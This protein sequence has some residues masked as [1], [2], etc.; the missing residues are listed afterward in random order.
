[1]KKTGYIS[2]FQLLL[3]VSISNCISAQVVI[4]EYSCSNIKRYKYILDTIYY[5]YKTDWGSVF[6][7]PDKQLDFI[8]S[9]VTE[10]DTKDVYIY[11][12]W[13][14]EIDSSYSF[15]VDNYDKTED[16]IE[17]YN[18][19]KNPV[20]IS[21]YYLSDNP[22]KPKKFKIHST[23][24]IPSGG[25][26]LIW[27]S[28]RDT[29]INDT[30]HASFK[31]TQTGDESES[32]LF[33]DANGQLVETLKI[34]K[35][36]SHHSHG[37]LIDNSE[38][39]AIFPLPTPGTT[40]N[41]AIHFQGYCREPEFSEPAG[42]YNDSVLI[43]IL[44]LD[45]T[46]RIYYTVDGSEPDT[47]STLYNG[48]PI[49]VGSTIVLKAL[50]VSEDEKL[51]S[52]FTQ[53]A[54]YFINEVHTIPVISIA[55][56]LLDSLAEGNKEC[57]PW[58]S[59]EYFDKEKQ[60]KTSSFGE[61]N[62]HGQDSWAN[63][64]RSI[65]FIAKDQ[66]G[67]AGELIEKFFEISDR[68]HFQRLILRAAGD[69][70]YPATTDGIQNYWNLGSAHMRDAYFQ[71][72]CK[73]GGM[74][75]DVRKATKCIIYLNGRYWGVYDIRENPDEHDYTK[76]YYDQDEF[77]LQ[78]ILTWG[79]TWA[80]YGGDKAL[81]D[82]NELR[83]F[84]VTNN[85]SIQE[86][87]DKAV[88]ELDAESLADYV[89]GHSFSVSSDWLLYN[90][91]WWRGL[92]PDGEHKRWGYILW[93]NDASFAFYINYTGIPDT[94][95][96]AALCNVDGLQGYSDPEK[97][98]KILNKLRQNSSFNNYYIMRYNDMMNTAFSCEN[99]LHQLDSVRAILEPEMHRHTERWP[100]GSYEEWQKNVDRLRYFIERRCGAR[101]NTKLDSCY[102]LTGPYDITF[103]A[104]PEDG[105]DINVNSLLINDFPWN[106][107]YFGGANVN[108]NAL[109]DPVNSYFFEKWMA[110]SN[111]FLSPETDAINSV[112]LI[113]NDEITA[114]FTQNPPSGVIE[115]PIAPVDNISLYPTFVTEQTNLY[116]ILEKPTRLDVQ[117]TGVNGNSYTIFS[118]EG[119]S[120]TPGNFVVE[121]IPSLYNASPG[122]YL[123]Y[124]ITNDAL[125]TT[126][127][128]FKP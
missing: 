35:T 59:F 68:T 89:I 61:F 58:G 41:N 44:S 37:R 76:Y 100:G 60:L 66:M 46:D 40:N 105:G 91:G 86:N 38:E 28:G 97:H 109:P 88:S 7:K 55:G 39:W 74:K 4:N 71:Y 3:I 79:Y 64:Q 114:A 72:L 21:G 90:T 36:Q 125:F 108:L 106:A 22:E 24:V 23:S 98:I 81:S 126:K 19:S 99:M 123:I 13:R 112:Q 42:F 121:I 82:W 77:D 83:K 15:F 124:V 78:F 45:V 62:S 101:A 118:S 63:D 54:T 25:F 92:D 52:S 67:Y 8:N 120:L 116:L 113:N 16:W 6:F 30:V 17:L 57:R 110:N 50:A 32:I 26:K 14:R 70:N 103:N 47:T 119:N 5:Y 34:C 84:I 33:S 53:F 27:A 29:V 65:D 80:E 1:M 2:F 75:L 95:A 20:D 73:T 56:T 11:I 104:Y 51:L 31:L 111:S 107:T 69:D 94:S 49:P 43:D 122:V 10:P 48:S 127:M 96:S 115:E 93:D 18:N 128:V 117:M 85:M 87:Y 102:D 12:Y 9:A